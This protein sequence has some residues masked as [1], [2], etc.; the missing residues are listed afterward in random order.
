MRYAY[1]ITSTHLYGLKNLFSTTYDGA[2]E[3]IGH[4]RLMISWILAARARKFGILTH[5]W[6]P[7]GGSHVWDPYHL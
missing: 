1:A 5:K 7:K 2:A 6:V 3:N 4:E